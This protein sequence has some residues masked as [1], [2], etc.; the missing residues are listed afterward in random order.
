MNA[1]TTCRLICVLIASLGVLIPARS[2]A[3]ADIEAIVRFGDSEPVSEFKNAQPSNAVTSFSRASHF[4]AFFWGAGGPGPFFMNFAAPEGVL[5]EQ[6]VLFEANFRKVFSLGRLIYISSITAGG[7]ATA[8]DL[9]IT[10]TLN[11]PAGLT[12]P[13]I[14]T[15]PL[16]ITTFREDIGGQVF[17]TGGEIAFP[18]TFPTVAWT[19][20]NTL[21]RLTLLGFGSLDVNGTFTPVSSLVLPSG[22]DIVTTADLFAVIEPTCETANVVPIPEA[23]SNLGTCGPASL[24]RKTPRW[25]RFGVRPVLE[26]DSGDKLE[27]ICAESSVFSQGSFQMLYTP[28]GSNTKLRVGLCPFEGGCNIAAFVHSGDQDNNGKPDCLLKTLWIS[29]DY[30][31]NDEFPWNP[32][33]GVINPFEDKL[34]WAEMIYDVTTGQLT[35]TDYKFEYLGGVT[36]LPS[37]LC[38]NPATFNFFKPEGGLPVATAVTDPPLG[39]ETEA[40][41][42]AVLARLAEIPPSGIPMGEDRSKR[43]D[44]NGDGRCDAAD[45]QILESALGK[46]RGE[47]GYHPQ[48]D[49][50]GS[51]CVDAQDRFHL[52]EADQDGDGVPDT[53]DNCPYVFNPD[54]TDTDGDGV[55]DACESRVVGD[56]DNDG[57]VDLDD[58]NT[59]LA[60]RNTA[61]TGPND[62]RDLDHDGRITV[63]DARK[64]VLL[65]TRPKCATK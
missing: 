1:S 17:G 21:Y 41:F 61:A 34:D 30:G 37:D 4:S 47:V 44:F 64:L 26:F 22:G 54:Q 23:I 11:K 42:D 35:K 18:P 33:T 9:Q 38:T 58:L 28:A 27:V 63:L 43:C 60:A 51:G 45:V 8:V 29:K 19:V 7:E 15:L 3:A 25:G 59:L 50:D 5:V 10:V 2:L 53:A 55:G 57:D 6:G 39:P 32:W 12:E 13:L 14:F 36:L 31:K 16:T 65:C 46:C 56:L 20:N 52:F 62:P 49:I 40:F 24:G 48:A